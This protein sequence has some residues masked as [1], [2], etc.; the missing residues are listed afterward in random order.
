VASNNIIKLRGI[1]K[2]IFNQPIIYQRFM[3]TSL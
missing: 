2:K 1:Q 3:S